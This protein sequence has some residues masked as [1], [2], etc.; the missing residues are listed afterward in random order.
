[1]GEKLPAEG[2]T[3]GNTSYLPQPIPEPV[4]STPL[5]IS[6]TSTRLELLQPFEPHFAP[7]AFSDP[8]A[9]LEFD[10]L[11][12]LLRIR[13]KC[14]TDEISAAGKWLKYKGHLSNLA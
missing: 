11:R 6:P 4:P 9:K 14:T 13:G 5:A 10:D 1:M 3:A 7:E 8:N 12:C 2:F